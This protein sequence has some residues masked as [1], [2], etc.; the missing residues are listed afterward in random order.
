MHPIK[1]RAIIFNMQEDVI[2]E[3]EK[4]NNSVIKSD[5]EHERKLYRKTYKW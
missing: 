4:M 1:Q 2:K 5:N 3:Y